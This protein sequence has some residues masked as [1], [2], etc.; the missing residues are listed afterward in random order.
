MMCNHCRIPSTNVPSK[1]TFWSST[2]E[3]GRRQPD[4]FQGR[5]AGGLEGQKVKVRSDKDDIEW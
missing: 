2:G 4:N 5:R 3:T 1:L